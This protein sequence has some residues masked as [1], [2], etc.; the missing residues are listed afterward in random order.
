MDNNILSLLMRLR[1][2]PNFLNANPGV[3]PN[4]NQQGFD[5]G[6][7]YDDTGDSPMNIG[8]PGALNS[9][10]TSQDPNYQSEDDY[11]NKH[12]TPEHQ[13]ADAY[14]Q[15]MANMPK[16]S[17]F[18]VSGMGK[19]GAFLAGLGT[20]HPSTYENGAAVGISGDPLKAFQTASAIKDDPYNEAMTDWQAREK[21]SEFAYNEEWKNN[22]LQRQMI[23]A[24]GRQ[25]IMKQN[26]DTTA[27][28]VA[29]KNKYYT[30]KNRIDEIKNQQPN[31]VTTVDEDSGDIVLFD[32]KTGHTIWTD[33]RHA[34][35]EEKSDLQVQGRLSVLQQK[36]QNDQKMEG[37]K[38]GG[39]LELAG[40]NIQG[41]KDVKAQPPGV[42][43][44]PD[45]ETTTSDVTTGEHDEKGNLTSLKKNRTTTRT[46]V[47]KANVNEPTV[48]MMGKDLKLYHVPQSQV[49]RAQKKDGMIPL[50]KPT[51][52]DPNFPNR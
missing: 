21:P 48:M 45:I 43:D 23:S 30:E 14:A 38:Q 49:D 20:M 32:K 28:N 24:E 31:Y 15:H 8:N 34:T 12:Y 37:V 7:S 42:A 51:S 52:F 10:N 25:A 1:N 29:A 18:P 46:Q 5:A 39:R 47:P 6:N 22:N 13:M 50:P 26:A 33:V 3:N 44:K 27:R 11:I 17:D 19:I 41:R 9:T 40:K 4:V 35:P 16:R 2:N 36:F